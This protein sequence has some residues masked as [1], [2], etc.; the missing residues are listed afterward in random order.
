VYVSKSSDSFTLS[1][2]TASSLTTTAA[3]IDKGVYDSASWAVRQNIV[4]ILFIVVSPKK[5]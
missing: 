2:F 3:T 1:K 5:L 4:L